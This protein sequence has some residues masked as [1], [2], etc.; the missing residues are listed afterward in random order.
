MKTNDSKTIVSGGLWLFFT[1]FFSRSFP[2]IQATAH[3]GAVD[4]HLDRFSI[5]AGGTANI[6]APKVHRLTQQVHTQQ[7]QEWPIPPQKA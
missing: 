6:L 1:P 5:S 2:Q 4:L 3:L 7:G